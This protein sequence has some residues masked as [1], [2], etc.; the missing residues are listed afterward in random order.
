MVEISLHILD[1]V[2]NSI[3]AEATEIE[4]FVNED[5]FLKTQLLLSYSFESVRF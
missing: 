4:I 2:Q 1:V 3:K 5:I